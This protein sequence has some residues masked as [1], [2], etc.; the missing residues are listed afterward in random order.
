[1]ANKYFKVKHGIEVPRIVNSSDFLTLS[2]SDVTISGN[3]KVVGTPVVWFYEHLSNRWWSEL[4]CGDI[5]M[6][7]DYSGNAAI[8]INRSQGIALPGIGFYLGWG[9]GGNGQ[10][11]YTGFKIQHGGAAAETALYLSCSKGSP[12]FIAQSGDI[13]F[14]SSTS[15]VH[16]SGNLDLSGFDNYITAKTGDLILS[17]SVGSTIALSGTLKFPDGT[18]MDTAATGG[19]VTGSGDFFVDNALSVSGSIA[20]NNAG[21]EDF[22]MSVNNGILTAS[23]AGASILRL[24]QVNNRYSPTIQFGDGD[25]GFYESGD[26]VIRVS[27]AAT[28]N[29]TFQNS[30][31]ATA[32]GNGAYM[33]NET[34]SSTNPV[35]SFW[36]DDDTGVGR[37]GVNQLSLI[38]Q[39]V[40]ILRLSSG[41]I[42][43]ATSGHLILSSSAGSNIVVS[44]T[45]GTQ[46]WTVAT[47]ST[48]SYKAGQLA[49]V[50]DGDGGSPCLAMYD[51]ADWKVI[52]LGATIAAA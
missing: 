38:A 43:E 46:E 18:T 35:W 7:I 32:A 49:Y 6:N 22:N 44:G 45:V 42:A 4:Y 14:S 29:Y 3:F 30:G 15:T 50:S 17:S 8:T 11:G 20:F 27:L 51:G 37:A 28:I 5:R 39:G 24:P 1:M 10:A 21:S 13:I 52:S 33:I 16:I 31:F 12:R 9:T 40:E 36:A 25:S 34:P 2:A 48:G 47:V 26:D 23:L 41:S 19:E